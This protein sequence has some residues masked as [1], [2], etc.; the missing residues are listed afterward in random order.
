MQTVSSWKDFQR[1]DL[2][3]YV[4]NFAQANNNVSRLMSLRKFSSCFGRNFDISIVQVV[5]KETFGLS[6][7]SIGFCV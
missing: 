2:Q 1:R 5:R 3:K 4:P 7:V 6:L